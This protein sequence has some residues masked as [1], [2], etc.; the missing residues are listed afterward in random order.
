MEDLPVPLY[1]YA[2]LASPIGRLRLLKLNGSRPPSTTSSI[3]YSLEEFAVDPASCPEYYALSYTWGAP[4]SALDDATQ[5]RFGKRQ[6]S[7]CSGRSLPIG[8]NIYEALLHLAET[9]PGAYFWADAICINQGDVKEREGQ[10]AQMGDIYANAAKVIV[11]LGDSALF[12]ELDDFLWLHRDDFLE[13]LVKVERSSNEVGFAGKSQKADLLAFLTGNDCPEGLDPS[14]RWQAYENFYARCRWWS[15]AWVVQEVALA[16][17]IEMYCGKVKLDW[18]RLRSLSELVTKHTPAIRHHARWFEE[19]TNL[20]FGKHALGMYAMRTL[21]INGGPNAE[22]FSSAQELWPITAWQK[23]MAFYDYAPTMVRPLAATDPRGKVFCVFG[24]MNRFLP[25]G[26]EPSMPE[27]NLSTEAV[28]YSVACMLAEHGP[29][30]SVLS[31]VQDPFLKELFLP[32]WV[33]DY[34]VAHLNGRYIIND[35]L[36]MSDPS[37]AWKPLAWRRHTQGDKL[38]LKGTMVDTV[39]DMAPFLGK[40]LADAALIGSILRLCRG[41]KPFRNS[42]QGVLEILSR[43][44]TLNRPN[45]DHVSRDNYFSC[46]IHFF[47]YFIALAHV[48]GMRTDA[49]K[50]MLGY[51]DGKF[52]TNP[53]HKAMMDMM[54]HLQALYFEQLGDW[55]YIRQ[56]QEELAPALLTP[57]ERTWLWIGSKHDYPPHTAESA[58]ANTLDM[59]TALAEEGT[60]TRTLFLTQRGYLGLGTHS[61][62]VGDKI[63]L[64]SGGSTPYCLRR[65]KDMPGDMPMLSEDDEFGLLGEVY[66]HGFMDGWRVMQDEGISEELVPVTLI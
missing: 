47:I 18:N 14:P 38:K 26:V 61:M 32:S 19:K 4:A 22:V 3:S 57:Q 9:Y 11:W 40:D 55:A 41:V 43:T 30:A 51:V 6:D 49:R 12:P 46:I 52:V 64:L 15:R 13:H 37:L 50:P 39:V 48:S 8:R 56:E 28:Y 17:L 34:S 44:L 1:A 7:Q 27:Y 63:M 60:M 54:V 66:L 24:L 5:G 20:G 33:P 58:K 21:C 45:F 36:M 16:Q 53:V 62:A 35:P 31:R 2:P 10:V 65:L 59:L 25:P 23:L 42:G 29:T